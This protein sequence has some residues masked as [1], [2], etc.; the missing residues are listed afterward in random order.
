MLVID[1]SR[2]CA[3][4]YWYRSAER[5]PM[6]SNSHYPWPG[7][8]TGENRPRAVALN[9]YHALQNDRHPPPS[10]AGRRTRDTLQCEKARQYRLQPATQML[11]LTPDAI[12]S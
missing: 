8:A 6:R 3:R 10:L 7:Q 9:R 2:H 11:D 1:I 4:T 5:A 12:A